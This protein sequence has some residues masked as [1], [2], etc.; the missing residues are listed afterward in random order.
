MDA[1]FHMASHGCIEAYELLYMEFTSR[2]ETLVRL[3]GFKISKYTEI[4][5][6]FQDYVDSLFFKILNEY[7]SSRG[8]FGRFCDYCLNQRLMSKFISM[9]KKWREGASNF[10]IDDCEIVNAESIPTEFSNTTMRREVQFNQFK[11]KMSSP[12]AS[13]KRSEKIKRNVALM[14]YSGFKPIEVKRKLDISE[15]RYR[16]AVE[17]LKK[18]ED[19]INLKLEMK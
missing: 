9:V 6:D 17:K 12:N 19:I 14:L 3:A 1:Y 15:C 8:P 5:I 7:D 2:A 13:P 11:L 16:N 18:D 4:F 10:S